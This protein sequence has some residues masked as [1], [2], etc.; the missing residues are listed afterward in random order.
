MYVFG[1]GITVGRDAIILS[2]SLRPT[3]PLQPKPCFS[4]RDQPITGE[5]C[6]CALCCVCVCVCMCVVCVVCA[7]VCVL[8]VLCVCVRER[9]RGFEFVSVYMCVCACVRACVRAC[10][11]V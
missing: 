11:C 10:V 8:C 9:E 7:S 4:S 3:T 2:D 6:A 5:A 1:V